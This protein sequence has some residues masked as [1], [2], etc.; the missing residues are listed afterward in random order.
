MNED[1][2]TPLMQRNL[3]RAYEA[4]ERRQMS[5]ADFAAGYVAA[6]IDLRSKSSFKPGRWM[7]DDSLPWEG[8]I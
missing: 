3:D 4:R 1:D 7:P 5:R 2:L 6:L 8:R